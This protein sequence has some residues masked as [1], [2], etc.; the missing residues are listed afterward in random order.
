M[1]TKIFFLFIATLLISNLAH[2]QVIEHPAYDSLKRT[3]LALDQEVYEVKLNLHQ[4]QSQLKTG[5]FVA[6]MG[7][8]ITII[9]GQLLGSNPDL[10]KSLLYVGGATGI[11]GTF[12]LVKG[13]KKLSLRAPDPPLGIR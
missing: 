4:A 12:V 7:Y 8:T 3:I 6:T 1:L 2:S 10:G 11:A 13:F 5:I 9:G